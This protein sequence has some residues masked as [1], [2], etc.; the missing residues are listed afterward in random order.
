MVLRTLAEHFALVSAADVD[1]IHPLSEKPRGALTYAVQAVSLLLL[2]HVGQL[3]IHLLPLQVH[4]AL[5]FSVTGK[6]KK[7][8]AR[9]SHFSFA[10]WGDISNETVGADGIRKVTKRASIF[11]AIIASLP[12]RHWAAIVE[13]AK[14]YLGRNTVVEGRQKEAM[15]VEVL[16]D[17]MFAN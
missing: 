14:E 7:P 12:D 4:R 3:G 10:N 8:G 9:E 6:F 15:V 13:G 1:D 11:K 5:L 17:P 16:I 2:T